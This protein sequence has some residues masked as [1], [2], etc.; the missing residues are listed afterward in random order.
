MCMKKQFTYVQNGKE[1]DAVAEEDQFSL[2]KSVKITIYNADGGVRNSII[3]T[4]QSES[5]SFD[6]YHRKDASELIDIA[7]ETVC[8][9]VFDV[10]FDMTPSH[11]S[12]NIP[13]NDELDEDTTTD[14]GLRSWPRR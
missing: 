7:I 9:G 10:Q 1:F 14:G 2:G 11:E 13:F 4:C 8:S 3:F 6:F 5:P 12:L